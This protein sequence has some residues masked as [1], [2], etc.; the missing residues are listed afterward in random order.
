LVPADFAPLVAMLDRLGIDRA[1]A[2]Y[3]IAYR[4]TF[5]TDE[6]IVAAEAD[7]GSLAASRPGAVLPAVPDET[8][9][10]PQYD[11]EVRRVAAPAWAFT[12]GS[13]REHRWSP[14]LRRT[15]YRRV[16]VDGFAVW[17]RGAASRSP[18][19]GGTTIGDS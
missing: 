17:H 14:L 10:R 12:A 15:G 4:L 11:R 5:E 8:N 3:W 19:A 18:A 6:R 1:Y 7:T 16:V 13:P 2:H 9:R